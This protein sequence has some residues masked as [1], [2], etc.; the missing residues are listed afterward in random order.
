[1][2]DNESQQLANRLRGLT[3]RRSGLAVCLWGEPGVGKTHLARAL[4]RAAPCSSFSVRATQPFEQVALALARPKHPNAWLARSFERLERKEAF[5]GEQLVEV[6]AAQLALGAPLV[7]HVEDLHECSPDQSQLWQQLAARVTRTR[8]A[9]LLFTSRTVPGAGLEAIRV[10]PLSRPESDVLLKSEMGTTL[11]QD[12]LAWI[13]ERAAGNPLFTLEFFRYLARQG[14]AWNDGQHWRWRAPGREVMPSTIEAIIEQQLLQVAGTLSAQRTLEVQAFLPTGSPAAVLAAMAGLEEAEL[15]AAQRLLAQQGIFVGAEFAHPLFREVQTARL[16]PERRRDLA[17]LALTILAHDP[18]QAAAFVE[19]AALGETPSVAVLT[20]AATQAREAGH[21][22]LEGRF[23]A[24]AAR[25]AHGEDQYRLALDAAKALKLLDL[26]AAAHLAELALGLKAHDPEALDLLGDIFAFQHQRD[27]LEWVLDQLPAPENSHEALLR[28]VRFYHALG[29]DARVLELAEQHPAVA[30][31]DPDWVLYT[32]WSLFE[33]D[34]CSEVEVLV[35][36]ILPRQDLSELHR[37]NLNYVQAAVLSQR[38][39]HRAAELVLGEALSAFRRLGHAVNLISALHGRSLLSQHLGR[40]SQ[41]LPDLEEAARLCVQLGSLKL[42]AQTNLTIAEQ[43]HRF[44]QYERA[45][46]LYSEALEIL[47]ELQVNDFLLDGLSGIA[48]LYGAWDA[49][50]SAVLATKYA[51]EALSLARVAQAP[52]RT[53]KA[54]SANVRA[55]LLDRQSARAVAFAEEALELASSIGFPEQL[56]DAHYLTASALDASGRRGEATAHA[57]EALHW[58]AQ[59]DDPYAAR[60]IGLELARLTE[61]TT[62]AREHLSWFEVHGLMNGVH[63]AH[64]AFPQ[65]GQDTSGGF[66]SAPPLRLEVLGPMRLTTGG[67]TLPVRGRKR[68]ELLAILLEARVAGRAE[69]SRLRLTESLYPEQAEIRSGTLLA[70]LVYQVRETLGAEVI[71]TTT[72]G[73]ALGTS[74]SSDAETFLVHGD[75]QLW[76]GPVFAGLNLAGRSETVREALCQALRIRIETSLTSGPV[77]AVRAAQCLL[78]TDPYDSEALRL[79]LLAWNTVG[80]SRG[81]TRVYD[82]AKERFSAVGEALPT[83]WQDFLEA[84]GRPGNADT[85]HAAT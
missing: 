7:L 68:Q 48:E 61:D 82:L 21:L 39:D 51:S 13:F 16:R 32:A 9:G 67:A 36:Q 3:A 42:L 4:L 84:P 57:R 47:R 59:T 55:S 19:A 37:A 44:G 65:L 17:R 15:E 18:L 27:R 63:L 10:R 6:L 25:H 34:R 49:P 46:Q 53:L 1:M 29:D 20:N 62:L 77:E 50:Y 24:Q 14:F 52:I 23:L 41:V 28:R 60:I 81:L 56:R 80:N 79:I 66:Q 54:L 70:D 2:A 76:R 69:V 83:R 26:T 30:S 73:Y 64:R 75:T 85:I 5:S 40:Y 11:P 71:T 8:G 22:L 74:V 33:Q 78:D 45:E 35:A 12:A 31:S 38:G 43:S 72:D 58:A